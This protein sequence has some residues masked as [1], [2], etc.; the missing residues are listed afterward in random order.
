M[1]KRHFI[2]E[3]IKKVMPESFSSYKLYRYLNGH[4]VK[5]G[6]Y[7]TSRYIYRLCQMG[8]IKHIGTEKMGEGKGNHYSK[9]WKC[10]DYNFN[11]NGKVKGATS[12]VKRAIAASNNQFYMRNFKK[13]ISQYS[14]EDIASVFWRL[15]RKKQ[16]L[17]SKSLLKNINIYFKPL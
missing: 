3:I 1:N 5:I 17:S 2:C 4:G 10:V 14:R 11:T 13:T 12:L 16:L 7:E 6:R 8:L 9:T 15:K